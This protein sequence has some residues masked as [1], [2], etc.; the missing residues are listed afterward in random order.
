MRWVGL[1][2]AVSILDSDNL[3][4]WRINRILPWVNFSKL[5]IRDIALFQPRQVKLIQVYIGFRWGLI[6][7]VLTFVKS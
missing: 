4:L 7:R 5:T 6:R 2:L 3:G 1:G